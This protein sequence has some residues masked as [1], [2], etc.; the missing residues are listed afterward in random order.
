MRF[1]RAVNQF[2]KSSRRVGYLRATVKDSNFYKALSASRLPESGRARVVTKSVWKGELFNRERTFATHWL[3]RNAERES[4]RRFVRI[5][6]DVK[7]FGAFVHRRSTLWFETKHGSPCRNATFRHGTPFQTDQNSLTLW[8]TNPSRL[9]GRFAKGA[10][11]GQLSNRVRFVNRRVC[12]QY[13]FH[14]GDSQLI[15][16]WR[17]EYNTAIHHNILHFLTRVP[18]TSVPQLPKGPTR[19]AIC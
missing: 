14:R 18:A 1:A 13:G 19:T 4:A 7:T 8:L 16:R 3:T 6:T 15:E 2:Q 12:F 17:V 9:T 5:P 10:R 11:T